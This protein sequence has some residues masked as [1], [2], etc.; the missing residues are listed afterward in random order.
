MPF[1]FNTVRH[2]G[3]FSAWSK[4]FDDA[5][6]SNSNYLEKFSLQWHQLCGIH[7]ALRMILIPTPDDIHCPGVLFANDVGLGKTIQTAGIIAILAG[8]CVQQERNLTLPPIARKI[9]LDH[10]CL[11]DY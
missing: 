4:E 7:A 9:F 8:I 2:S 6:R 1:L 11:D 5:C 3:G 10:Q